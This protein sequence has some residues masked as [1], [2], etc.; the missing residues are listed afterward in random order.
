MTHNMKHTAKFIRKLIPNCD[1]NS[2]VGIAILYGLNNTGIEL[3]CG[4]NF[5]HQY[6][7]V[8][9]PTI[10]PVQCILGLF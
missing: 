6:R 9:G 7:P 3:Q 1:R 10:P 4:Q 8:L 2:S 5:S